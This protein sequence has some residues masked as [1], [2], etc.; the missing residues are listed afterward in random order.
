[1][2]R[3]MKDPARDEHCEGN[4]PA[5]AA[6]SSQVR[7]L[8]ASREEPA[9]PLDLRSIYDAY[10]QY[11]WLTLQRLGVARADLE[12]MCQEVFV[13]VHRRLG[14]YDPNARLAAWLFGICI[15]IAAAYHRRAFRR[16]E[17]AT[18]LSAEPGP[19]DGA[20]DPEEQAV[21]RQRQ[22]VLDRML[23]QLDL[24]HRA[25]FVMFEIEELSC[26]EIAD[27]I[28]IPVGTVYSRLHTARKALTAI[29]AKWRA[30]EAKGGKR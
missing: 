4:G 7:K 8:P 11:V 2:I 10:G 12:D 29:A 21:V 5:A 9:L 16:R 25:V 26:A 14:S 1:M 3:A 15:K 6:M 13:V 30:R 27:Q 19:A 22:V 24:E 23:G 20:R 18:D 17:Q 28:G